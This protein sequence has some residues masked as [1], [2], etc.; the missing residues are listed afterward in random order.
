MDIRYV[1]L[2]GEGEDP[3]KAELQQFVP[4]LLLLL[5]LQETQALLHVCREGGS[6]VVCVLG[7]RHPRK[8]FA[9]LLHQDFLSAS[10][11]VCHLPQM[12]MDSYFRWMFEGDTVHGRFDPRE[13][14]SATQGRLQHRERSSVLGGEEVVLRLY[15]GVRSSRIERG[16]LHRGGKYQMKRVWRELRRDESE[17]RKR[18]AHTSTLTRIKQSG[19]DLRVEEGGL[20]LQ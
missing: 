2:H 16:I 12:M 17:K 15:D 11:S 18:D 7:T 20:L 5:E 14:R 10:Q 6:V 9:K 19:G 3:V 4:R 13:K 1:R 8:R